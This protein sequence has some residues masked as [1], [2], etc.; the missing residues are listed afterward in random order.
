MVVRRRTRRRPRRILGLWARLGVV[1]CV[2]VL[3]VFVSVGLIAKVARPYREAGQEAQA[4]HK[5]DREIAALN[6]ENAS[7]E[8]QINYLKTKDG[9]TTEARRLNYLYPGEIPIVV[10]A[11]DPGIPTTNLVNTPVIPSRPSL[12]TQ[13]QHLWSHIHQIVRGRL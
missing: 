7:L 13:A 8:Q 11:P 12:A 4:L 9:I 10:E 1:V 3:M 6:R 2:I 5:N